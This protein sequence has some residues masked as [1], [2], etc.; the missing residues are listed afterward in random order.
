[1]SRS[2]LSIL[3]VLLPAA[4]GAATNGPLTWRELPPL[5]DKLGFAG[6]Y[7]GTHNGALLV[8]G[9]ANVPGKPPWEQGTK[10]WYDTVFVLEKP[11]G[12][13]KTAGKLPR[14]L[15]YGVSLSTKETRPFQL[16]ASCVGSLPCLM[17]SPTSS[18]SSVWRA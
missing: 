13:W 3:A 6:P 12:A 16:M 7:V 8:A 2:L 9:G 1:M 15:G 10:V 17:C 5:P 18:I 4:L 11:D 14:P